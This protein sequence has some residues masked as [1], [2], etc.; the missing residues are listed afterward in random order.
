MSI[1]KMD[2]SRNTNGA[3][4]HPNN[5]QY[6][7]QST[8][9]TAPTMQTQTT[10]VPPNSYNSTQTFVA[11]SDHFLKSLLRAKSAKEILKI[12]LSALSKS[13]KSTAPVQ[14]TTQ[15]SPGQ[16]N[17][18][19]SPRHPTTTTATNHQRSLNVENPV[20]SNYQRQV[21]PNFIQTFLLAQ[22]MP[23]V[24]QQQ[25]QP[26]PI[27]QQQ[28][29]QPMPIVQQQ[30]AQPM[31]IVQQQQAQP[32]PIVQQQQAQPMPIVQQQQ[33]QP[34]PI[35]QRYGANGYNTREVQQLQ[36]SPTYKDSG[37]YTH[38]TPKQMRN[39]Y[40][41]N[42]PSRNAQISSRPIMPQQNCQNIYSVQNGS[43]GPYLVSYKAVN[44][45]NVPV[46]TS[47]NP[48]GQ[49]SQM[50]S[51]YQSVSHINTQQSQ[52]DMN[53]YVQNP[54]SQMSSFQNI[55]ANNC[56]N[57]L[58]SATIGKMPPPY[59]RSNTNTSNIG[60]VSVNQRFSNQNF[61]AQNVQQ[62]GQ[63]P[64]Q[65]QDMN[66]VIVLYPN[67]VGNV[68]PDQKHAQD[69]LALLKVYR[70]VK[71]KYLL[72][73]R[74]NNLL[75]QK[76]QS[77][78]Q[79]NSGSSDTRP[80]LISIL[81]ARS[82]HSNDPTGRLQISQN[83]TMQSRSPSNTTQ[84]VLTP[85]LYNSLTVP[86]QNIAQPSNSFSSHV[87]PSNNCDV[88]NQRNY[89]GVD[90][91]QM[92][93]GS[94]AN[95]SDQALGSETLRDQDPQEIVGRTSVVSVQANNLCY[96]SGNSSN[97]NLAQNGQRVTSVH[98][99][100]KT[101]AAS[102]ESWNPVRTTNASNLY[103]KIL[104]TSSSREA[105][106]ASLPLW[107]SVPQSFTSN[108]IGY[109]ETKPNHMVDN[110]LDTLGL[111]EGIAACSINEPATVTLAQKSDHSGPNSSK[112]IEPQIAIVS[113]LVQTK[114]LVNEI[115]QCPKVVPQ[116]GGLANNGNSG[117][118]EKDCLNKLL[119][120]LESVDTTTMNNHED[121]QP[122]SNMV[123]STPCN[124]EVSSN[125]NVDQNSTEKF[126]DGLQ[127]SGI[128]TLVEG[129]SFYDS[130]IAMMFG[131]SLPTQPCL[132]PAKTNPMDVNTR[133]ASQEDIPNVNIGGA[134]QTASSVS[135]TTE[136]VA[137]KSDPQEEIEPCDNIKD[138][139]GADFYC[140]EIQPEHN[141]S[142]SDEHD[143]ES[144][145]GSDQLSE[146]L[147]EFPFGIKNYMS[148]S[149]LGSTAVSLRNPTEQPEIPKSAVPSEG[150]ND[151]SF[152]D[153]KI[154]Y[155][156]DTSTK[157]IAS[158]SIEATDQPSIVERVPTPE[159]S[160]DEVTSIQLED[161]DFEICD[162]PDANIHI[163]LLDQ[164][165]ITK[166]F[167]EDSP[168]PTEYEEESAPESFTNESE[169]PVVDVAVSSVKK[170]DNEPISVSDKQLFCCLFSWLTHTNGNAPKCNCKL[171]ELDETEDL[172][173][174][175][176]HLTAVI[177]AEPSEDVLEPSAGNLEPTLPDLR[178]TECAE[179]LPPVL[180][181]PKLEP[182]EHSLERTL[183][184]HNMNSS[185]QEVI[186][187][188]FDFSE[189]YLNEDQAPKELRKNDT[190]TNEKILQSKSHVGD[191][192]SKKS[193]DT[194]SGCKVKAD[195]SRKSE[196]LIIKTDFLKNKHLLKMKR[197]YKEG[198]VQKIKKNTE[199]AEVAKSLNVGRIVGGQ[200]NNEKYK[201][202]AST[203]KQSE[204]SMKKPESPSSLDKSSA[205][206]QVCSPRKRKERVK[207]RPESHFDQVKKV[208]T[209]QE[210]LERKREL[211]NKKSG[212]KMDQRNE[213]TEVRPRL[214]EKS[215]MEIIGITSL[216][217]LLKP[218]SPAKKNVKTK[219][220]ESETFTGINGARKGRTKTSGAFESLHKKHRGPKRGHKKGS[221]V[222]KG[223]DQK[224]TS[225]KEKIYLSPCD[226]LN[227]A[228][229]EGISL[230][231]LQIRCSPE[232]PGCKE[233]RKSLDSSLHYKSSKS[234]TKNL[235]APKML[236]FKLCPEFI[237]R[238]PSSQE[239]KGEPKAAKEKSVVEGIKSKKEAWCSGG[240][241][242]KSR[243][244]SSSE[245]Q[246][247]HSPSLSTS[248][249]KSTPKNASRPVQ[250][251]Q[252][253]FNVF[254]QMYHEQRS[255]SLDC[256]L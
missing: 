207:G 225:S 81:P 126:D 160:T 92:N 75:R 245:D 49:N 159:P 50:E 231:K 244:D 53:D 36:S 114:E 104:L 70:S 134:A 186:K 55:F 61:V 230:T 37:G 133:Q 135:S 72:L 56:S 163:T 83:S 93:I 59:P 166:L 188:N 187:A 249:F 48:N 250:D 43:S 25:A 38:T 95:F 254:K 210:Y 42:R 105:I 14:P 252:T 99:H 6:L 125:C 78:S 3:V 203:V 162:S 238:S 68:P 89:T 148:K 239:R 226:G 149:K 219:N 156:V 199:V 240:P 237:N 91:G 130:S 74:E 181:R 175:S 255:K 154:E 146:L 4:A 18:S 213:P 165:Q 234:E 173:N 136:M 155:A 127:I 202:P 73:N 10:C 30:Q 97:G 19:Y 139:Q 218:L 172:T 153:I 138:E 247:R 96:S 131:G 182:L 217:K 122:R 44:D 161:D 11:N 142:A 101:T 169:A 16:Y 102:H 54:Q 180:K 103:A 152:E 167:P 124:I 170:S 69:V 193:K 5:Q 98:N 141:L 179:I 90:S 176:S 87:Y 117:F 220:V 147:T 79:D 62:P 23:V 33:A 248:S 251:S 66:S 216:A 204:K 119:Q 189:K 45:T 88:L 32:M 201:Q 241:V 158:P 84:G 35:V 140:P 51:N 115:N 8:S 211:Y 17:S 232:K 229:Y 191:P 106:E 205:S 46:S 233:R 144:N 157:E 118:K 94:S 235:E 77:S 209:V 57:V 228:S 29:A 12:Q 174:S 111:L 208:P 52:Q 195:G 145:A 177:K 41:A 39:T 108:K 9:S 150:E 110:N 60:N 20:G 40:S 129:N 246:G 222:N 214:V 236:E 65:P 1:S 112:G 164:D 71:Q 21:Y 67:H 178:K 242:K 63:S 76:M 22:P 171:T 196:K 34:M 197:K 80:P 107:K 184:P 200:A 224:G 120:A 27:V 7:P 47:N 168:K 82:V 121:V 116:G 137:V 58:P 183:S 13:Q 143:F 198:G 215:S 15:A 194:S 28:Q 243:I 109:S 206:G 100:T 223:L 151:A 221:L 190:L 24:Q 123:S 2:W 64:T 26:M 256:S 132:Q 192:N 185:P 86:V 85:T 227:R 212:P 253:T 128:C 31:P 113:P